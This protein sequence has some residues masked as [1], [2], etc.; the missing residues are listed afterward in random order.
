MTL[1]KP[2]LVDDPENPLKLRSQINIEKLLEDHLDIEISSLNQ[3]IYSSISDL[4]EKM[5]RLT[6]LQVLQHIVG[7]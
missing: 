3:E 4:K 6:I 2:E 7:D 1:P 5:S